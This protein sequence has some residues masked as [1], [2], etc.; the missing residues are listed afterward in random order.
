[1]FNDFWCHTTIFKTIYKI[2]KKKQFEIA[3]NISWLHLQFGVHYAICLE[4]DVFSYLLYYS[5]LFS[6]L[7]HLPSAIHFCIV[8]TLHFL[9]PYSYI[10]PEPISPLPCPKPSCAS[11]HDLRVGVTESSLTSVTMATT[12]ASS[13]CESWCHP[14]GQT[15][16]QYFL[17]ITDPLSVR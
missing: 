11:H 16:F 10:G 3:C 4:M 1:M 9:C 7:L 15:P 13:P 8:F 5:C 14:L 17:E 6:D 2:I 12:N